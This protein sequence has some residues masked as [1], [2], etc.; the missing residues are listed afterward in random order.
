VPLFF[1]F[2]Q[3]PSVTLL[4]PDRSVAR[5]AGLLP[6]AP[7]AALTP[8]EPPRRP[9]APRRPSPRAAQAP[10][11]AGSPAPPDAAARSQSRR[12]CAMVGPPLWRAGPPLAARLQLPYRAHNGCSP[13]SPVAPNVSKLVLICFEFDFNLTGTS[14]V[15]EKRT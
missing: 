1:L 11:S 12:R 14:I 9:T 8:P 7:A 3:P 4:A 15:I 10:T 6:T 2:L 5:P 13:R